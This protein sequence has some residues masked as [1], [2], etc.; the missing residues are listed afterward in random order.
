MLLKRT[1][2]PSKYNIANTI[3]FAFL[4]IQTISNKA[5]D[6]LSKKCLKAMLEAAVAWYE[7]KIS[8]FK[9]LRTNNLIF[10]GTERQ[11]RR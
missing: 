1:V 3:P 2:N 7:S 6:V 5:Y 9:D 4:K 10:A 8:F 11:K